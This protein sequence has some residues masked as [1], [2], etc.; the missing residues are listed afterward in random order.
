MYETS[1]L[2]LNSETAIR[3]RPAYGD[4]LR[5]QIVLFSTLA[6]KVCWK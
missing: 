3:E 5:L 4:A 1:S 6:D 2:V